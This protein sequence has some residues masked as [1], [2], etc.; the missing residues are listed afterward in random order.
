MEVHDDFALHAENLPLVPGSGSVG[1]L[2]LVL[3]LAIFYTLSARPD[4]MTTPVRVFLPLLHEGMSKVISDFSLCQ[5]ES[6]SIGQWSRRDIEETSSAVYA[7]SDN[8]TFDQA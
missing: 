4:W 7:S 3:Q 5:T 2:Y 6:S 1:L 8:I